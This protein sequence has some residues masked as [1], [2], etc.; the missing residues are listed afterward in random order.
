MDSRED[1]ENNGRQRTSSSVF[2]K[3]N[4][5]KTFG[6]RDYLGGGHADRGK[7]KCFFYSSFYGHL[8]MQK[9]VPE[10][11]LQDNRITFLFLHTVKETEILV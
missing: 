5:I 7:Q 2:N 4:E 9:V 10:K 8:W 1:Q 11:I 6:G 3:C